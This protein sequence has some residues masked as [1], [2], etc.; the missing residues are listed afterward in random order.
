MYHDKWIKGYHFIS[1]GSEDGKSKTT[2][3]IEAS[4][5]NTQQNW[6][7][8]K[9]SEDY[10][11]RKP[12]FVFLH[13]NLNPYHG[14]IG[15][16]QSKE[17]KQILSQYPEVVLFTS[18]THA[19]LQGDS[20][21]VNQPFTIVHTGAIQYTLIVHTNS[22][23]SVI[24]MSRKHYIKGVYVEVNGN[25]VAI[26]ERNFKEKQWILTKNIYKK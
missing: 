1:L 10:Q 24:G 5:S 25:A 15:V 14:W 19:D 20:I 21:K 16:K 11:K 17:I 6:L 22:K 4:I 3:S 8:E 13:E 23:D 9:L 7:K 2:N 12:I 18:H 26:K